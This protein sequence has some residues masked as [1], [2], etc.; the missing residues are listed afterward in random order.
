MDLLNMEKLMEGAKIADKIADGVVDDQAY[1]VI[2][3]VTNESIL[4]EAREEVDSIL[5]K[6]K[7]MRDD[8]NLSQLESDVNKALGVTEGTSAKCGCVEGQCECSEGQED[9]SKQCKCDGKCK[10]DKKVLEESIDNKGEKMSKK[11]KVEAK[12]EKVVAKV[13]AKEEKVVAKVEAKEEKAEAIVEG[14]APVVEP[15]NADTPEKFQKEVNSTTSEKDNT[16]GEHDVSD[17]ASKEKVEKT[18]VSAQKEKQ[19]GVKS[20]QKD[21]LKEKQNEVDVEK[22]G[23]KLENADKFKGFVESIKN[24]ENKAVVEAVIKAFDVIY[25]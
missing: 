7:A 23:A 9:T 12:E 10:C 16:N 4:M 19:A 21:N 14:K 18:G 17:K 3:K 15:T 22:P 1:N 5:E 8:V 11:A 2:T 24:D 13:E 20:V 25:K 6:G